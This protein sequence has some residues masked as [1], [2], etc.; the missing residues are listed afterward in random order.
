MGPGLVTNQSKV[1]NN[2]NSN[3]NLSEMLNCELVWITGPGG[4]PPRESNSS[5]DFFLGRTPFAGSAGYLKA[6]WPDFVGPFLGL[7]GPW[8]L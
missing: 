2:Q 3:H 7:G 4:D 8:W 1:A 5:P 6:V